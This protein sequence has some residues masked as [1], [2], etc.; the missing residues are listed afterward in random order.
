MST[1]NTATTQTADQIDAL[2]ADAAR[3][4]VEQAIYRSDSYTEVVTLEY[5]DARAE[6]L[7]AASDDSVD[8]GRVVEFWGTS[9]AGDEWRVHLRRATIA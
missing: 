8:A 5:S 2:E 3:L 1:T 7:L 9:E 6:A 4:D